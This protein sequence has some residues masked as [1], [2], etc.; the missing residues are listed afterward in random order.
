MHRLLRWR[1]NH[2]RAP[3]S[4]SR[5]GRTASGDAQGCWC[6]PASDALRQMTYALGGV[7]VGVWTADDER[8][9]HQTLA[10]R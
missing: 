9:Y 8:R 7:D 3:V 10:N 5:T 1:G 4:A 2:G 6:D